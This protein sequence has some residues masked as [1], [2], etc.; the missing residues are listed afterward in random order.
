[1]KSVQFPTFTNYIYLHLPNKT[2][3][4]MYTMLSKKMFVSCNAILIYLLLLLALC[5]TCLFYR[6]VSCKYLYLP[7]E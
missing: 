1:M 7:S 5:P 6:K 4:N 2:K 3:P